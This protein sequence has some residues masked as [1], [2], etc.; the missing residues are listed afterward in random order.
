MSLNGAHHSCGALF[1][2]LEYYCN[3]Y[4]NTY[5]QLTQVEVVIN[6]VTSSKHTKDEV[7]K[8]SHRG[9]LTIDVAGLITTP[10]SGR[11]G[12]LNGTLGQFL[13]CHQGY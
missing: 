13:Y 6:G 12:G 11:L 3:Q 7:K 8:R 2:A 4:K 1:I 5:L 10:R 9:V